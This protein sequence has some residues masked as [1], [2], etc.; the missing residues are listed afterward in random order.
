MWR[1]TQPQGGAVPLRRALGLQPGRPPGT[2][3]L[4]GARGQP[5][6]HGG[7]AWWGQAIRPR[8][9][10]QECGPTSETVGSEP[11]ARGGKAW[12]VLIPILRGEVP[13]LHPSGG[14]E[15]LSDLPGGAR[16]SHVLTSQPPAGWLSTIRLRG[17]S[18]RFTAS[19]AECQFRQPR[20]S[21][22]TQCF[23]RG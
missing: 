8:P 13:L 11:C 4:W 20:S 7:A 19:R 23:T 3:R 12:W 10:R 15:R 1:H 17:S 18:G 16:Q 5:R 6:Q 9:C 2:C 22:V 14:S 21:C